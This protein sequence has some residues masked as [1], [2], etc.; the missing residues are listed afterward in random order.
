MK[1]AIIAM[2]L[3]I[4]SAVFAGSSSVDQSRIAVR[5][6]AGE[7]ATSRVRVTNTDTIDQQYELSVPESF[8]GRVSMNP[9]TF[10]LAP[11]QSQ[12]VVLRFRMPQESQKTHVTLVSSDS[13]QRS[14]LKVAIGIRVP[15]ELITAQVAGASA[16]STSSKTPVRLPN[17]WHS[18]VYAVDGT[19][20]II[21]AYLIRRRKGE[22]HGYD[23][24]I[25][26]V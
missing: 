13:R 12:G 10:T 21:A 11:G 2:L 20:I 14:T 8:S 17:P 23:Y 1:H 5:G 4:P 18:A 25:S 15:V 9:Q 26:F 16:H 19:L 7:A 3:L 6:T 22:S 24:Q